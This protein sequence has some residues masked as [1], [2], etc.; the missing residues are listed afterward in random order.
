MM[1]GRWIQ[2]GRDE[3]C[4][5]NTDR[6]AQRVRRGRAARRRGTLRAAVRGDAAVRSAPPAGAPLRRPARGA[7]RCAPCGTLRALR[8]V[9]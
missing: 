5:F 9:R 4:V 8:R 6:G 7:V 2:L 3:L 1:L